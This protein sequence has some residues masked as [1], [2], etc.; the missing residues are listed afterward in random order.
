MHP[1]NWLQAQ[2]TPQTRSYYRHAALATPFPALLDTSLRCKTCSYS[3]GKHQCVA[4][5]IQAEVAQAKQLMVKVILSLHAPPYWC[6]PLFLDTFIELFLW[7]GD[8]SFILSACQHRVSD[9][10]G[11]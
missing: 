9:G 4:F 7:F 11:S 6:Q 2:A 1:S 3:L 5:H 8:S 10:F